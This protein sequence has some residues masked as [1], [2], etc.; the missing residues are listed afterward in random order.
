MSSPSRYNNAIMTID[1]IIYIDLFLFSLCISIYIYSLWYGCSRFEYEDGKPHPK[2]NS[3]LLHVLGKACI[4][5]PRFK[6][7]HI[8]SCLAEILK[9][10]LVAEANTHLLQESTEIGKFQCQ[11]C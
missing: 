4:L 6:L 1:R 2:N 10:E 5:D 3:P 7:K 11:L 9:T 8:S